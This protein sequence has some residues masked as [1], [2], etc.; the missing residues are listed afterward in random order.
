MADLAVVF[1]WQPD[2]MDTL[3]LSELMEWR[4]RARKRS[5]VED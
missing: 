5:G 3:S 1:H 4:E 2:F